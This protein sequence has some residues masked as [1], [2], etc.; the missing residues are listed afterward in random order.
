MDEK[1]DIFYIEEIV[2]VLT[3]LLLLLE[4]F[5]YVTLTIC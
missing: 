3:S 4:N 1:Y 2:I 5:K